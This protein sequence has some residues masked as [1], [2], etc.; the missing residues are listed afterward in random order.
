MPICD[1]ITVNHARRNV[2]PNI[3]YVAHAIKNK[4][5]IRL[6]FW[7]SNDE[8][9]RIWRQSSVTLDLLNEVIVALYKTFSLV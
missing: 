3:I 5:I 1:V 2:V 9:L 8:V 6:S 7:L 4:F